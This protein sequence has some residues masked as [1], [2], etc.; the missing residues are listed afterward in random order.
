MERRPRGKVFACPFT[1]LTARWHRLLLVRMDILLDNCHRR[2]LTPINSVSS[3][4]SIPTSQAS[5][6][7]S[8]FL[9]LFLLLPISNIRQRADANMSQCSKYWNGETC[10]CRVCVKASSSAVG[11]WSTTS[12][13]SQR[14]YTEQ[15]P[16]TAVLPHSGKKNALPAFNTVVG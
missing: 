2:F 3:P 8:S 10:C 14:Q 15:Q 4:S 1:I 7:L 5:P 12:S 11:S 9:R 13:W 6:Y 16:K